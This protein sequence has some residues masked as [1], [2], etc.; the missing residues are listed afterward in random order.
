MWY[1]F[2]YPF[3]EIIFDSSQQCFVVSSVE[4][5]QIFI[6]L[7]LRYFM[8]LLL[9]EVGVLKFLFPNYLLLVCR[10]TVY[11]CMNLVSWNLAKFTY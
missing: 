6:K 8:T 11:F 2:I 5:M 10:S 3:L 7:L 9:L 1:I 4:N